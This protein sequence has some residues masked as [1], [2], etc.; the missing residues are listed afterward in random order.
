[1][2][3]YKINFSYVEKVKFLV[4]D[5][6]GTCTGICEKVFSI[7]VL[8]ILDIPRYTVEK[9]CFLDLFVGHTRIYC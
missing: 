6:V 8:L 1:M 3:P 5:V 2:K 4:R 7:Y 9:R